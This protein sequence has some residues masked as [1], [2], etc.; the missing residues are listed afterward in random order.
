M[1]FILS[2]VTGVFIGLAMG[3]NACVAQQSTPVTSAP[4]L[5]KYTAA[6]KG[7]ELIFDHST[8][9]LLQGEFKN[10]VWTAGVEIVLKPGWKTY[11]RVPGDAGVPSEFDWKKSTN[12]KNIH[13]SWPAP[14]RYEDITGK[15]IGYKKHVV[16]PVT[17]TPVKGDAPIKLDLSLYYAI[18]SDICVPAQAN[19]GLTLS[20]KTSTSISSAKL[21]KEFAAKVPSRDAKGVHVAKVITKQVDGKPVLAVTLT[22]KVDSKTDILVEG[23]DVAFFDA[24]KLV[25][26]G[27]GNGEQIFHL[28]IDGIEKLGELA[29]NT[30]ILTVLSGDIRLESNVKLN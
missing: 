22:G 25:T 11:W 12:I 4:L 9:R 18:C 23:S 2:H 10:G 5:S 29:G 21:I 1:R 30:L 26:N 14:K 7:S 15:S 3:V 20:N 6:P 27:T 24:P 19:L 17:V 16:F 28:S 13:V 8:V